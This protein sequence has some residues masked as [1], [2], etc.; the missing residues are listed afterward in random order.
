MLDVIYKKAYTDTDKKQGAPYEK[1]AC[2]SKENVK[3]SLLKTIS[4]RVI[5][6][7]D[8]VLVSYL[9]TG[10]IAMALSI[11]SFEFVS[12]MILYFFHERAWNNIKWGK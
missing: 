9:V 10:T 3:R 2:A 1:V 7:L 5:G 8:T 12:K 11:G 4:W 6:T